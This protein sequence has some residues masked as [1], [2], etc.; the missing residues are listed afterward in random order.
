MYRFYLANGINF[1][2]FEECIECSELIAKVLLV[3]LTTVDAF[4][5][6][7]VEGVF[8]RILVKELMPVIAASNECIR[9]TLAQILNIC[10]C[11]SWESFRQ[12]LEISSEVLQCVF[13]EAASLIPGD[14]KELDVE[15]WI[16]DEGVCHP[17]KT[18]FLHDLTVAQ[19]RGWMRIIVIASASPTLLV[20]L[21]YLFFSSY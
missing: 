14:I 3:G 20:L 19:I 8:I 7:E 1:R 9:R 13:V 5:K 18:S 17:G 6:R 4:L 11:C 10:G 2:N 15:T 12:G 21:F 16:R